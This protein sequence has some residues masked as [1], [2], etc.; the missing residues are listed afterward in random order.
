[1][2]KKE[3]LKEI[4]RL[5]DENVDLKNDLEIMISNGR[6][7]DKI[8]VRSKYNYIDQMHAIFWADKY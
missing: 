2:S 6:E 3:L 5:I 1:M 4:E 8:T 7:F